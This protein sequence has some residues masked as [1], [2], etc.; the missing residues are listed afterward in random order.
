MLRG[1]TDG[2]KLFTGQ[3]NT[4]KVHLHA[5]THLFQQAHGHQFSCFGMEGKSRQI[6]VEDLPIPVAD[7]VVTEQVVS[8]RFLT[9]TILWLDILSS[10]T[11]G[12]AP[13]LLSCHRSVIGPDAQIQLDGLMGCKNWVML[14]IGRISALQAHKM[15]T[16][17]QGPVFCSEFEQTIGD[18]Q[19]EIQCGLAQEGLEGFSLSDRTS[20]TMLSA[21]SHPHMVVTHVFACMASIY[22]HLIQHDFQRLDLIDSTISEVMRILQTQIPPNVLPGLVAPLYIIGTVARPRDEQFFRDVFS[23]PLLL[24]PLLEHRGKILPILEDI[25][26]KR[27]DPIRLTWASTFDQTHNLLLH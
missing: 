9:G 10:I 22:L 11:A 26:R 6:L 27:K 24:D 7:P 18:I 4:W 2:S 25:W 21:I 15:Q 23:S 20:A 13:E 3:G 5:A 12:T 19:K 16:L 14:Q 1:D 8:F 17:Q